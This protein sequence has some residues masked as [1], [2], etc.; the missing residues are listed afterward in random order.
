M[1]IL[2]PQ[3]PTT[4]GFVGCFVEKYL[5][6]T[7]HVYSQVKISHPYISQTKAHGKISCNLIL[8]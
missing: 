2:S 1:D 7:D 4:L 8:S 6:Q 5:H 3:L